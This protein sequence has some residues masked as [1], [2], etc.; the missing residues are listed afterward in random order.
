MGGNT[1][2]S[3][4]SSESEITSCSCQ[5][6]SSQDMPQLMIGSSMTSVIVEMSSLNQ[7]DNEFNRIVL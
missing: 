7:V 2:A 5:A 6:A 4:G 1:S 3:L